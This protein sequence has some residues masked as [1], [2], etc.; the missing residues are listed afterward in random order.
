[1][2]G[3]AAVLLVVVEVLFEGDARASRELGV[4]EHGVVKTIVLQTDDKKPLLVLMHGDREVGPGLL[5]KA[6]GAK[7]VALCDPATAQKH[8]GYLFGGTSPLG[9]RVPLPVYVERTILDLPRLFVNGGKRGFLVSL[10]PHALRAA[11]PGLTAVDAA[12]P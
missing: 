1:R 7:S 5:A 9:T 2:A 6:I 12:A 8:T 3:G 10:T 4:D 11:L